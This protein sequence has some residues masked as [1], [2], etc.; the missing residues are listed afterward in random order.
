LTPTRPVPTPKL[1]IAHDV[2]SE[3]DA[4]VAAIV[5]SSGLRH[6]RVAAWP[7]GT[8]LAALESPQSGWTALATQ[9]DDDSY[10]STSTSATLA[11]DAGGNVLVAH[12]GSERVSCQVFARSDADAGSLIDKVRDLFPESQDAADDIVRVT[13]GTGR[14]TVCTA[15]RGGSRYRPGQ[16]FARTTT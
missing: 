9:I 10:A 13:S 6:E 15:W 11:Q 7:T 5:L 8:S 16:R 4:V 1:R 14:A 12:W 2:N 3:F